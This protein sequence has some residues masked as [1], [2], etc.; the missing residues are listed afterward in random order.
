MESEKL[1]EAVHSIDEYLAAKLVELKKLSQEHI[2]ESKRRTKA[3]QSY[4]YMRVTTTPTGRAI[5][6]AWY[7]TTFIK[8]KDGSHY[9]NLKYLGK[10]NIRT[11]TRL[12]KEWEVN[13]LQRMV[14]TEKE[15]IEE[16][17]ALN[18]AIRLINL[19]RKKNEKK[20]TNRLK[21]TDQPKNRDG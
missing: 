18:K 8:K 10:G 7:Y 5:T 4:L 3:E 13:W 1:G 15:I 6:V 11:L 20:D 9:R 19:I 12:A 2:T 21:E 14:A 17:R 16:A